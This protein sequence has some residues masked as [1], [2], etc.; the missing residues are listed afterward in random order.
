MEAVSSQQ[1]ELRLSGALR[2]FEERSWIEVSWGVNP[3]EATL[4]CGD[5]VGVGLR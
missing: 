4:W 3:C 1:P 2:C 5:E